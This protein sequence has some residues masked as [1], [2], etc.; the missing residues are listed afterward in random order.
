MILVPVLVAL[1]VITV[2]LA[3]WY[4]RATI[5]RAAAW[6]AA[7]EAGLLTGSADQGERAAWDL[8]TDL[9]AQDAALVMVSRSATVATAEVVVRVPRLAPGFPDAVRRSARTPVER[10]VGESQR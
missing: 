6:R 4:H 8:L 3:A 2:Q 7:T 5:A 10:F 1:V 9:G